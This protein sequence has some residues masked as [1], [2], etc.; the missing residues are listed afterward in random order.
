[1]TAASPLHVELPSSSQLKS[2]SDSPPTPYT[3]QSSVSLH[4]NSDSASMSSAKVP[5]SPGSPHPSQNAASPER[6]ENEEGGQKAVFAE[7]GIAEDEAQTQEIELPEMSVAPPDTLPPSPP[8]TEIEGRDEDEAKPASVSQP[9]P[10]PGSHLPEE[11]ITNWQS[12]VDGRDGSYHEDDL[13]YSTGN[14]VTPIDGHGFGTRPEGVVRDRQSESS[15]AQ[16]ILHPLRFDVHPPSP[17][18]WEVIQPP[19][20]NNNGPTQG[21][22]SPSN[23]PRG[24]RAQKAAYVIISFWLQSLVNLRYSLPAGPPVR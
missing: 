15:A 17:P 23:G 20:H 7:R 12:S 3:P 8:L 18:L 1:M 16:D 5:R 2:L 6:A 14:E 19:N 10:K 9:P 4:K 13:G 21:A 22:L 11:D 24:Y